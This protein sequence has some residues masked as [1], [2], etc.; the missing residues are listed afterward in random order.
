MVVPVCL[1]YDIAYL[2]D[3]EVL[4]TTKHLQGLVLVVGNGVETY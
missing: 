3:G 4:I 1:L 2:A